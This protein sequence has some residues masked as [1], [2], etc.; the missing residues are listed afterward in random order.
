MQ[1]NRFDSAYILGDVFAQR[2]VAARGTAHQHTPLVQQ[3]DRQ[4]VE[5]GL[6]GIFD[7][8]DLQAFA[9]APIEVGELVIVKGIIQRQHRYFVPDFAEFTERRRTD[10]PGRGILG[11]QFR[12]LGFQRLQFAQQAVILRVRNQRVVEDVIPV[13][14]EADLLPKL[15]HALRRLHHALPGL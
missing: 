14:M 13:V 8:V 5:L 11:D 3:T 1:R 6:G 2:T 10:A 4:P 12:M 7:L 15:L 9:G